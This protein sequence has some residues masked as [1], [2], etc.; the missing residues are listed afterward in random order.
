METT[1]PSPPQ[2]PTSSSTPQSS[3]SDLSVTATLETLDSG[4]IGGEEAANPPPVVTTPK[5]EIPDHINKVCPSP[6]STSGSQ[7]QPPPPPPA[8]RPAPKIRAPTA[9]LFSEIPDL[10]AIEEEEEYDVA[11]SLM[12]DAMRTL[13]DMKKKFK[14]HVKE[15]ERTLATADPQFA[16]MWEKLKYE[17]ELKRDETERRINTLPEVLMRIS[18]KD[19]VKS[20]LKK[21]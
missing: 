10:D 3:E 15:I 12:C 20:G 14:T 13:A 6:D 4:T 19:P 7:D 18:A 9:E 2:Q 5:P 8:T 1:P 17:T 21:E 16:S 11:W